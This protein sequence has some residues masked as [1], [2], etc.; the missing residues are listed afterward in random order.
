MYRSCAGEVAID[1]LQVTP[2]VPVPAGVLLGLF[3]T[4]AAGLKLRRFA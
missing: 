1:N 2:T 3:G 4:G